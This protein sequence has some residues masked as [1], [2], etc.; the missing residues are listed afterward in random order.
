LCGAA[1]EVRLLC[2]PSWGGIKNVV[3]AEE[4]AIRKVLSHILQW[5]RCVL[6]GFGRKVAGASET[7]DGWKAKVFHVVGATL[8][9][10]FVMT[11]GSDN[12]SIRGFSTTS[13]QLLRSGGSFLRFVLTDLSID[14]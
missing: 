12:T 8:A 1:L 4:F 6:F 7:L 11:L 9:A 13:S 14:C 3:S 2:C 10:G 5:M